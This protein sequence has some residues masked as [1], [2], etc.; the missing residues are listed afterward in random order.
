M[1]VTVASETNTI[2][3]DTDMTGLSSYIGGDGIVLTFTD[4]QAAFEDNTTIQDN[5]EA[6]L[7]GIVSDRNDTNGWNNYARDQIIARHNSDGDVIF[8]ASTSVIHVCLTSGNTGPSSFN[9]VGLNQVPDYEI[10]DDEVLSITLP[11]AIFTDTT[12]QE[13]SG[14]IT[15]LKR[16]VQF[17]VETSASGTPDDSDINTNFLR[18]QLIDNG[19]RIKEQTFIN[20]ASDAIFDAL[21][22]D[23]VEADGWE[24]FGRANA[25]TRHDAEADILQYVD[26][27]QLRITLSELFDGVWADYSLV[28]N[29]TL[30]WDDVIPG[31]V[32][33]GGTP[34]QPVGSVTIQ[35]A[36]GSNPYVVTYPP[37]SKRLTA[38]GYF[39]NGP[40]RVRAISWIGADTGG[41][42]KIRDGGATGTILAII[43]TTAN[44]GDSGYFK[45]PE[46][47]IKHSTDVYGELTNVAGVTAF[48]G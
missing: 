19:E 29:E 21:V 34:V 6:I 41:T 18:L 48:Y 15:I 26:N 10:D 25:K 42:I 4:D 28:Y 45:F 33:E 40:T 20:S 9:A 35:P 17:S 30:S 3:C 32:F 5:A 27:T 7:N 11:A 37:Q 38:S 47:G 13:V 14:T 36:A 8:R 12:E 31:T 46:Q 24:G 39:Y 1:T 2:P 22:A 44:T 16:I 43:D 23:H